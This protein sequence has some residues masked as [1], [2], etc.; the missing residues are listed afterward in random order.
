M[1]E[2]KEISTRESSFYQLRDMTYNSGYKMSGA[3]YIEQLIILEISFTHHIL[4][5]SKNQSQESWLKTESSKPH[6]V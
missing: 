6:D 3:C 2:N 5:S 4:K 1:R